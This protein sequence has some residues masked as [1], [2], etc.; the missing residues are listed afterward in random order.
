MTEITTPLNH[1]NM[2]DIFVPAHKTMQV[3]ETLENARGPKTII[4]QEKS[5]LTYVL[6]CRDSDITLEIVHEGQHSQS[7]IFC[8][9]VGKKDTKIKATVSSNLRA[10]HSTSNVYLLSLLPKESDIHVDGVVDIGPGIQK[11]AGHLLEENVIL[12]EKI[13]IKTLP[14]LDVRS[15]DV[16]ASHGCRIDKVDSNKLFY[17]MSKGIPQSQARQLIVDGYLTSIFEKITPVDDAHTDALQQLQQTILQD[18]CA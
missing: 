15:N 9:F 3:C 12:G 13:K 6:V 18:V 17:M 1:N 10:D 8:I 16:S 5:V 4:L 11:V 14:M 2:T 7:D